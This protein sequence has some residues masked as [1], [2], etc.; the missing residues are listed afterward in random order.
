[1]TLG[2]LLTVGGAGYAAYRYDAASSDR[3]MPGVTIDGVEVGEMSR[4][5][6][7]AEL[8]SRIDDRLNQEIEIVAGPEA[9]T[10]SAAEL[11]TTALIDPAVDRAL[12]V[13]DSYSW[14][15]R[16]LRR[17]MNRPVD[18]AEALRFRPDVD[19]I[20]DFVGSVAEQVEVDPKNAQVEYVDGEMVV[21][22]PE[23]GWALPVRQAARDLRKALASGSPSVTLPM[24]RLQPEVTKEDL[25]KT[26]VVDLSDLQLTLYDGTKVEKTYA[27]AAG[28]PSYPTPPGEW[29]I[30]DKRV[31]P[32]WVNPAPDG[33]G[34]GMP[35]SIPGGP[36][37]PLG[38]RAL[39]LDA[40]G[41]RI[42]GTPASY[43]IGSYASH[44]CI[45]MVMPEVEELYD[46]VPIGTTVHVVP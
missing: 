32:T 2:V 29:T 36:S 4:A 5:Q 8:T 43:S 46:I 13:N 3:L 1:L 39:Y 40:P 28:S 7:V 18:V 9:W 17:V 16:V 19:E 26:I 45:R 35:A 11:G 12:A 30:W 23:F 34:K 6:A 38:T 31:N 10:V 22:K 21:D 14:P 15:D 41:I 27:V 42:H 25:G 44:G 37:S 24:E 33:W 20:R